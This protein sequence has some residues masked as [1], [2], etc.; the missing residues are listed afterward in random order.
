MTT[1]DHIIQEAFFRWKTGVK[2]LL[3]KSRD[4]EGRIGR[5]EVSEKDRKKL[6]RF[7]FEFAGQVKGIKKREDLNGILES[8]AKTTDPEEVN[9]DE[10]IFKLWYD[11]KDST[12]DSV[13]DSRITKLVKAATQ[14]LKENWKHL[15]PNRGERQEDSKI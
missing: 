6:K 13:E 12:F 7:A 1:E 9:T 3:E 14:G 5:Y 11:M 10:D 2:G 15:I 4:K 8:I